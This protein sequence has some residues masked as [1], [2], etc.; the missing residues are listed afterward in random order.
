M[1]T[2]LTKLIVLSTLFIVT[3]CGGGGNSPNTTSSTSQTTQFQSPV[4]GQD[5]LLTGLH[6]A[7]IV[8]T[9]QQT[10]LSSGVNQF[11]HYTFNKNAI[12]AQL[13]NGTWDTIDFS[14]ILLNKSTDSP[15]AIASDTSGNVYIA[16]QTFTANGTS[17][18]NDYIIQCNV[19]NNNCNIL[20]NTTSVIKSITDIASDSLGNL[21]ITGSYSGNGVILKSTKNG[22]TWTNLQYNLIDLLPGITYVNPMNIVIDN[23]DNVF[24]YMQFITLNGNTS[25]GAFFLTELPNNSTSWVNY[26]SFDTSDMGQQSLINA[27]SAFSNNNVLYVNKANYVYY[28]PS[29]LGYSILYYLNN[30][31]N[32][33]NLLTANAYSQ[34]SSHSQPISN[35]NFDE[36]N[37]LYITFANGYVTY[38]KADY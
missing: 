14:N 2:K 11:F 31:W 34:D 23:L 26:L 15:K 24:V 19:Q 35:I 33:I 5:N 38:F 3:A 4:P 29:T 36:Q 1:Q 9:S 27:P 21:Y 6:Y 30:S 16:I 32:T 37:N 8:D 22:T 7:T 18:N 20:D 25:S 10:T 17:A 28:P 12:L 13:N